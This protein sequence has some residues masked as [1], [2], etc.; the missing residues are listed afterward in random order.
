MTSVPPIFLFDELKFSTIP[1]GI[2]GSKVSVVKEI[3]NIIL[4]STAK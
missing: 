3:D 4:V 1:L 2:V